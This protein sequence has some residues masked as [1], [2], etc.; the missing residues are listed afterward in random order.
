MPPSRGPVK[1]GIFDWIDANG[2]SPADLYEQRLKLLEYADKAGFYCYHMA[3]HQG[4]P[5]GMAPSPSV[6]LSALA[7]RTT[8]LRFGPLV[9]PLP[10]YNPLRLIEEICMLDHL[11]R[12][13]LEVGI[14][15]GIS[16]YE[17]D[18]FNISVDQSREMFQESLE[19]LM[20]GL[21][22]GRVSFTGK[23]Y[24]FKNVDLPIRA[25]Q[26]PYPP[27]WYP[28]ANPDSIKW[29][30]SEGISTVTHYP[31]MEVMREHID[32]YKSVW[33]ENRTR[34]DRLNGHVAVPMYGI[35]RHIYLAETDAQALR[36][37]R[38]GFADFIASFNHLRI[39]NGDDS[40]RTDYL[41]DFDGRLADGL[42]IVGSPETVRKTLEEHLSITGSNYFVGSFLFGTLS[43]EQTMNS[44]RLFAEKVM[45]HFQS[46]AATV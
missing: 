7:Q 14:G 22:T 21:R 35:T 40:G 30:A 5:L 42:H 26:D 27:L 15:R 41:A 11:S 3:E 34:P 28:T 6:F 23:H 1:F 8:K 45:P 38:A 29:I 43:F 20:Q 33:E 4:T 9:Y 10:F 24:T 17:L 2:S 19:I 44:L 25:F 46:P 16:A 37:T 36:E 32:L 12:G 39:L 18:F 31:P 13:R